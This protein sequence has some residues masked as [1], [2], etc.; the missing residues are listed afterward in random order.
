MA[1]RLAANASGENPWARTVP[2][3]LFPRELAEGIHRD[4]TEFGGW[5]E[6]WTT[7]ERG[8]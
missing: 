7:R 8:A 5:R 4:I 6:Y 1:Q 2:G 3:I